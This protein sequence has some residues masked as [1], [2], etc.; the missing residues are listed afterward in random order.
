MTNTG[1]VA[2]FGKNAAYVG[3]IVGVN[4]ADW[5]GSQDPKA[6]ATV[7]N[8]VNRMSGDNATDTRRIKL[9]KDLSG[10]ATTSAAS[11]AATA[12]TAL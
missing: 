10:C 8:C 9:L 1:L 2:A 4:D 12:K 6:T 7:Q 3:G 5:G 11:R